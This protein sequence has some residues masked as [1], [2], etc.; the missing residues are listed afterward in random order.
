MKQWKTPLIAGFAALL[1]SAC[2]SDSSDDGPESVV[3]NLDELLA[4]HAENR[5]LWESSGFENYTFIFESGY[6]CTSTGRP[7]IAVSVK[8][9]AVTHASAYG[10]YQLSLEAKPT[11]NDIFDEI[12]TALLSAPAQ[13]NRARSGG[14]PQYHPELGVPLSIYVRDAD[15][16][17]GDQWSLRSV[18][19]SDNVSPV[20]HETMEA[21]EEGRAKWDA[22]PMS[23]YTLIV[24]VNTSSICEEDSTSPL[25][26]TTY[27]IVV[28]DGEVISVLNLATNEEEALSVGFTLEDIFEMLNEGLEQMP[29]VI[30]RFSTQELNDLVPNFDSNYG[31]PGSY[32][33]RFPSEDKPSG[34][35]ARAL[36]I[37]FL[38]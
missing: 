9:G 12:E 4:T 10:S 6:A 23:D 38:F 7:P 19:N 22:D 8:N 24:S 14:N 33:V 35:D 30:S 21:M 27:E 13:V 11:I 5:A 1:L 29:Q 36:N 37:E 32:Y 18:R 31:F 3:A 26:S 34:C 15:E 25:A 28:E 20:F 16:F 2:I 17:C